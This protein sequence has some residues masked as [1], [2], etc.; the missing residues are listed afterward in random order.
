MAAKRGFRSSGS[1]APP[2][3][4]PRSSLSSSF[5][6]AGVNVSY[7]PLSAMALYFSNSSRSC[8]RPDQNSVTRGRLAAWASRSA[9]VSATALRWLTMPQARPSGSVASSSAATTRSQVDGVAG[10]LTRATAAAARSS[11]ASSAGVMCSGRISAK[12]GR[13]EKSSS[14]LAAG[15][16]TSGEMTVM[17]GSEN[18]RNGN[19][20]SVQPDAGWDAFPVS[21]GCDGIAIL[22][23]M[24]RAQRPPRRVRPLPAC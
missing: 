22:N 20:K 9:G 15:E 4:K 24:L 11:S 13:P 7:S 16:A 21:N 19:R 6:R 8:P 18:G 23:L 2:R 5:L 12:R 14:G 17:A 3:R 10:S 1:S